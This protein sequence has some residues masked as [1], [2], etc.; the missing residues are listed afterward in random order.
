MTNDIARR[1]DAPAEIRQD[2]ETLL[3]WF[4]VDSIETW[5]SMPFERKRESHERFARGFEAFLMEGR[6]PTPGLRELF[7]RFRSWLLN[8]YRSMLQLDVELTDDVRAVMGRMLASQNE[9]A[10]AEAYHNFSPLAEKPPYMSDEA[11]ADYQRTFAS[12][13]DQG[14]DTLSTR[15]VRDM[16]WLSGARSKALRKLQSQARSRRKQVKAEVTAEV[17][18][19]PVNRA[20]QYL[21]RGLG[22]DGEP[23]PGAQKLDLAAMRAIYGEGPDAPWRR[24]KIGGKYGE[25]AADGLHPDVAAELLGYESG[26]ALVRDLASAE[27]A[28]QKI[29]GMTDQRMLERYGDM[30]DEA[31]IERAADEAIANEAHARAIA[32]DYAAL[33]QA[34]GQ[35]R[36]LAAAARTYA[37]G[38]VNRIEL[39]RLKPNQF[40]AAMTRAGKAADKAARAGDLVTAATQRR[41]QLINL[42]AAKYTIDA[43][44]QVEEGLATF[45]RIISAK[46]DALSRSRDMALVNGA[47]AILSLYGLGRVKN[48]P[49]GYLDRVKSYDPQLYADIQPFVEGARGAAKP[50]DEITFEQFQGLRDTINQLWVLSRRTRQIELDG[51]LVD[52]EAARQ[53]LSARLDEIGLP[54]QVPGMAEAPSPMDRAHRYLQGA[55]AAL[56][57]VESWVRAVDAT[58][59]GPFRTYIWNPV[60]TA[61]DRYRVEQAAYL[62]RF[63]DIVRPIESTLTNAKIAAPEI[64]YTFTGKAELLHAILHTGNSSNMSKLLLGRRWGSLREDGSLD[65]SRWDAML[66]RMWR[67]GALTKADYD[68]AQGV[69]DLL[70]ETKIG[71]QQAHRAMYGRYFSEVTAEPIQTP[72]GEY[73]GGYVP[74]TTD[75]F[76]VQDAQLRQEQEALEDSNAFMFPAASN[77]FTKARVEDYTRELSLDIRL[78]PMHIDKV[79]RFTHLGPPVR[80]VARLLR[81]RAFSAKL[82]AFDPVAASDM[83]LPWLQRAARQV[84]QEP[85]K[86]QAGRLV[87]GFFR[88][89]RNRTGM[90]LMFAN[91]SNTLQ[92]VTGF[93]NAAVRVRP[94]KI[95]AGMWTYIRDPKGTADA[96]TSL[97]PF[98]ASRTSSQVFEMRQT[99]E[100]LLLNPSK[101]EKLRD[102]SQRHAYFMQFALQNVIDLSVWRGAYNQAI[103]R[104]DA[105]R[106]AIRFAD[107][108]IRETQ[109]AM[110]PEDVSRFETG[111]A[112]TRLF[113]QFYS[114]FN[115]QAN[116]L[117]TEFQTVART[118]G[119]RN[120]AGRLLYLYVTAFAVPA[121]LADL[122]AT[123]MRGGFEDDEEDG[124]LDEMLQWFAGSQVRFAVAGVPVV[125]QVAN[126]ALGGFT[127]AV[128]DDRIST[129]PAISV[130]ESGASLP[131]AIYDAVVNGEALSRSDVRDLFNVMGLITGTPLG[132]LGRPV[133]YGYAVGQGDV[134]PTSAADA[135]RGFVTGTPSPESRV[136]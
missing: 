14:V 53:A 64:G 122:I 87:D 85:M 109:S 49:L 105:E 133:S 89:L 34:T 27:D 70:D 36:A 63:L 100:Q 88:E 29:A 92:Q 59:G 20:R 19:E 66:Q 130:V 13:T 79:L 125:G 131:G 82:S 37:A 12:A 6:A 2:M 134:E 22:P 65:T 57:R 42:Q 83:L 8:V 73:R 72:F 104:G 108:V 96:I 47:R 99:I 15:A 128:Y 101:Y 26:D 48:D 60:S 98:M 43:R 91:L 117:G 127:P 136:Q 21:R 114:Y 7:Q 32:T 84:V 81:G 3:A 39:K 67:E 78:L 129:S 86:G 112:F 80:D 58:D 76:L 103:E 11:W 1:P 113:T 111:T 74:A 5:N 69:W 44:A 51:Q 123:L 115:N 24:L 56:R 97:S 124:Y 62:R 94:S 52:I 93:S 110:A 68:F 30:A 119:V 35:P 126:A 16:R 50:L 107:S 71:A 55:R 28:N 135:A 95:A 90:Q 25:A 116:L 4:G 10:E 46:D 33:A 38:I 61:A 120:G 118:T 102:F 17:M 40:F 132:A 106:E 18:A 54:E 41:N 45:Q 121:L 23:V 9:I 75:G 31:G 77:G